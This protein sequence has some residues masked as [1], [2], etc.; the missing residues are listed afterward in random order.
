MLPKGELNSDQT[1]PF[2]YPGSSLEDW[3]SPG[4]VSETMRRLVEPL[5]YRDGRYM[6]LSDIELI[7]S[8]IGSDDDLRRLYSAADETDGLKLLREA[9]DRHGLAV[10]TEEMSIEQIAFSFAAQTFRSRPIRSAL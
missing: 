9:A 2:K 7:R 5:I 1:R 8:E 3:L 4:L 6:V 10:V